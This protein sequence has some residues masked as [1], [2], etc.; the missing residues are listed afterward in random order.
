MK[1][2]PSGRML[3]WPMLSDEELERL[4]RDPESDR[5][6]RKRNAAD[7]DDIRQAVC[8]FANDLPDHR[9]PGVVLVGVEDDGECAKLRISDELVRQLAQIRDDGAVTPFPSLTVVQRTLDGCEVL[10]IVVEPAA[11]PPV[12]LRGRTWI[13]VG[14]RRALATVEEEDRLAE[15]RVHARLPYDVQS[16]AAATLDDLDLQL[17]EREYLPHAV[18]PD[19]V[20]E[21][22]RSVEQQLQSLRLLDLSGRPTVLG[23]LVLGRDSRR[24][25]PGAYV[26][27]LRV[28]GTGLTDPIRDQKEI[29]GPLAELLRRLDELIE[30]HNAVA[31]S[32]TGTRV[33]IRRPEYPLAALQQLV[34]NAVMHRS[35]EATH[36]PVR[37]HW[38]S[39][40]IEILSPGGPYGL[41]SRE[42]FGR[43]GIA[44]YRNPHLAEAMKVLGYVQRFGIGIAIARAELEK[45]GNPAPEFVIE[46]THVLATVR[47]RA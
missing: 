13:R 36:A 35:Y 3:W 32:I 37:L 6:E 1:S 40:R 19:V 46:P 44:D 14:P 33:D 38:Y 29:D 47:R 22:R 24:Y 10:V 5:V 16:V 7:L 45:N 11:A 41:V 43:P 17:F 21:N 9:K 39:D 34:R 20:A 2:K 28:E 31:I 27:F 26:Q 23:L 4:L 30:A 18:A 8:A 25:V 15:R 42:N 12:R